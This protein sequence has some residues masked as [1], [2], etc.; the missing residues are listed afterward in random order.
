[1]FMDVSMSLAS[2][3]VVLVLGAM[4]PGP[5]FLMVARTAL[6]VSRR[7]GL[8]AALGM[9]VGGVLLCVVALGG[10][11]ALFAAVPLLYLGLQLLGGLYL[12]Y[13]GYRI[14]RGARAQP[15]ATESAPAESA[16]RFW[17]SFRQGL[18]TQISNPKTTIVY[19][20]VFASLLPR[21]APTAVW[22]A[23]PALIFVI[24]TLWYGIVAL[25]LS[26]A[27]PRARYLAAKVWIDR[28][29]GTA[30]GLLGLKLILQTP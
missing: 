6:A 18:L 28:A 15:V 3:V 20:S 25:A 4:S 26:A 29:A 30:M 16:G 23:L 1:M 27:A 22:V 24:E 5:S 12:A 21:E 2:L 13:L 19:A 14:W 7:D 9:G 11:L 10:L 8:A 17:L